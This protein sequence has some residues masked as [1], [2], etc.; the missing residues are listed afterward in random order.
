MRG[1]F[2]TV[3]VPKRYIS[4]IR[5]ALNAWYRQSAREVFAQR[6]LV[7]GGSLKWV[8][9][10]PPIRLQLMQRQWAAA[11]LQGVSH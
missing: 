8:Y 9:E 5:S 6:L 7:I 10:V 3:V 2:I 4:T 1:A 11:L